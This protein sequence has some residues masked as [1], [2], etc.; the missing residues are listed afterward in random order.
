MHKEGPGFPRW[1]PGPS[2]AASDREMLHVLTRRACS[3]L[4]LDLSIL[5][6]RLDQLL[7]HF[8]AVDTTAFLS[9]FGSH[10]LSTQP[11]EHHVITSPAPLLGQVVRD[12]LRGRDSSQQMRSVR[13]IGTHTCS[14]PAPG[15]HMSSTWEPGP[16]S[17]LPPEHRP[18]QQRRP[19]VRLAAVRRLT[20]L[21][22]RSKGG[23]VGSFGA[24]DLHKPAR[25]SA[26]PRRGRLRPDHRTT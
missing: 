20:D 2:D 16:T 23:A 12:P 7:A 22:R 15:S 10:A 24:G 8:L 21:D 19:R 6:V 11:P 17:C 3:R 1:E 14:R 25:R 18:V 9:G 13:R 26:S 4:H 5:G